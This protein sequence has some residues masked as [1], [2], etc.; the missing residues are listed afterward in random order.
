MTSGQ[1]AKWKAALAASKRQQR[2]RRGPM[3]DAPLIRPGMARVTLWEDHSVNEEQ[4]QHLRKLAQEWRAQ[5][6]WIRDQANGHETDR[7]TAAVMLDSCARQL[8]ERL[9]RPA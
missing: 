9:D 2:Q 7:K 4:P 1:L 5:A 8:D 6:Q 3:C